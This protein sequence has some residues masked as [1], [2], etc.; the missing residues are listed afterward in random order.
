MFKKLH[1]AYFDMLFRWEFEPVI[2]ER[3]TKLLLSNSLVHSICVENNRN[4]LTK[5]A[6]FSV[7]Y[8]SRESILQKPFVA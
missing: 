1:L 4:F 3:R 7:R 2:F 6:A 8:Q 5:L